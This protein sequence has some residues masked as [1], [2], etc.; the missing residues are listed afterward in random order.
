MKHGFQGWSRTLQQQATVLQFAIAATPPS[1]RVG[2]PVTVTAQRG[3]TANGIVVDRDAVVR[4][5][6]GETIVWHHV[7]PEFFEPRPIRTEPF[8]A[9]RVLIVAGIANGERIVV[10]GAEL[11]NQIR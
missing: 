2:Q 11:I 10:R 5:A 3:E 8:D 6:N 4:G 7:E 1:A 9:M